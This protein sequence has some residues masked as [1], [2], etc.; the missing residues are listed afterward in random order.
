MGFGEAISTVLGKYAD[1][2]GRARRREYWYWFLALVLAEVLLLAL[3]S[4]ADFFYILLGLAYLAAI[5]PSIAVAVRRLHDTDRSGW[6][7]LAAFVPILGIVV[8]AFL[9]MDGTP[10]DNQYGPNP[11]GVGGMAPPMAYGAPPTA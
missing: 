1:F 2:S 7:F 8:L 3:T 11:K 10:G 9:L 4:V 6:W 5:V